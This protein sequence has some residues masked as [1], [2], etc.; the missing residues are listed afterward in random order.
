MDS[1]V[2]RPECF[3]HFAETP[4]PAAHAPFPTEMVVIGCQGGTTE[5]V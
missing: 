4:L 5:N 2:V 1:I 3:E